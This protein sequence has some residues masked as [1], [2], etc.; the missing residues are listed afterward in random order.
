MR[1]AGDPL[2]R[3]EFRDLI[4]HFSV[5]KL[6]ADWRQWLK[7]APQEDKVI[8]SR[9]RIAPLLEK[10]TSSEYKLTHFWWK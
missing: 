9:K 4:L 7:E 6:F 2:L 1:I 3:D 10:L 5:P 8:A